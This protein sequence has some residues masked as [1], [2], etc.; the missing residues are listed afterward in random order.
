[1]SDHNSRVQHCYKSV[2]DAV[3]HPSRHRCQRVSGSDRHYRSVL[4]FCCCLQLSIKHSC[5][6]SNSKSKL[7]S[8]FQC[9]NSP[10]LS[11]ALH[12]YIMSLLWYQTYTI[13]SQARTA[14]SLCWG[15]VHST[16][17]HSPWP[18]CI[19]S[20]THC[21]APP[22]HSWS[23]LWTCKGIISRSHSDRQT[24]CFTLL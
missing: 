8:S 3:M 4:R 21:T 19:G 23:A 18:G 6:K 11:C 7:G 12:T 10:S 24:N 22:D 20:L 15:R 2:N 13:Y 9:S 5:L 17:Y 1:M 14:N 16:D